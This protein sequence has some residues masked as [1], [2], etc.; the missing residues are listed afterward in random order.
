MPELIASL[1]IVIKAL[2]R[3]KITPT[4]ALLHPH[5]ASKELRGI[6]DRIEAKPARYELNLY[7]T[8]TD[9]DNAPTTAGVAS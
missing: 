7:V 2:M 5:K 9:E 1:P 8:G 6:F 3:G 4:K